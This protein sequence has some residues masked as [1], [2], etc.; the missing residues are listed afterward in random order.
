MTIFKTDLENA[1]KFLLQ[2]TATFE[3]KNKK[4]QEGKIILFQQR[5]FYLI[6]TIETK[7]GLLEKYEI[8][9]PY[10]IE[11][12]KDDN[13]VYFDYR[14]KALSKNNVELDALLKTFPNNSLVKNKFW[15]TILSIDCK[16]ERK[17]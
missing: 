14:I 3:I 8:P 12:D 1:C 11:I 4:I 10:H 5:N 9:I 17:A 2:K 15:D 6:F 13:L 16:Y 7:P